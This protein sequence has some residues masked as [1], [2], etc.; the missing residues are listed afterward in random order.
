MP[1]LNEYRH[2]VGC[3][4]LL[5]IVLVTPV[6]LIHEFGHIAI[7]SANGYQFSIWLDLRGGHSLCYGI[8]GNDVLVSAMGGIFGLLASAGILAVWYYFCKRVM[9]VAAV[10]MALMLDQGLKIALEGFFPTFYSS[11]RFDL[12]ITLLQTISVAVFAVYLA[13]MLRL[14]DGSPRY[15]QRESKLGI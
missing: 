13:R 9:P 11:G 5:Y 4:Y 15:V 10:A 1:K 14:E 12:F 6:S 2:I 8:P 7:C 3:S